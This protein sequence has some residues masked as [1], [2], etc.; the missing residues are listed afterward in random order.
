MK[1]G[2]NRYKYPA[3]ATAQRVFYREALVTPWRGQIPIP[4]AGASGG[5]SLGLLVAPQR[6]LWEHLDGASGHLK[7]SFGGTAK[8]P[9]V[10]PK[11]ASVVVSRPALPRQPST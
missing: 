9:L 1:R 5:T 11:A 3:N 6:G 8:G 2:A 10:A 7:R 4:R